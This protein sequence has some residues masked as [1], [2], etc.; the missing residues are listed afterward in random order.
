V[1]AAQF[2]D[3][4]YTT[5]H[6]SALLAGAELGFPGLVIWT[7]AVYFAFKIT[8]RAQ[9]DLA[10]R[11]DAQAARV[12]AMALLASLV[13]MTTSSM[14]LT[15]TYHTVLWIY[16]GLAGA[17]YG[18]IR[19]HDPDFRVRFTWRDLVLVTLGDIGLLIFIAIYL[20]IKGF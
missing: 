2:L 6:N 14:F 1:G 7:A 10:N 9:I 5:A 3:N 17:L 8:I 20:R 12:W 16:L 19:T 18:A 15:L 11:P 13:G 4:Y